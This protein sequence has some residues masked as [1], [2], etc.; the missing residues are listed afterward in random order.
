MGHQCHP[1]DGTVVNASGIVTVAIVVAFATFLNGCAGSS[2]DNRETQG[3]SAHVS[4][5][6]PPASAPVIS[7]AL[8]KRLHANELGQVMVLEYHN[9]I[10]KKGQFNQSPS[11][12][13]GDLQQL[14][15]N[16]YIPIDIHDW[17]SGN[18]TTPAGKSPVLITFDDASTYQ[19]RYIETNGSHEID[20]NC[21]VGIM[22]A[23]AAA[24]P[25]FGAHATFF[26][27]PNGFSQPAFKAEKY[28]YL[29]SHGY[30]I[31]NHTWTHPMLA[32]KTPAQ[33]QEE[34]G[35]DDADI[36]AILPNYTV[37]VLAYPYGSRPK[38]ANKFD[39]TYIKNGVWK[40]LPYHISAAFLVGA[41]PAPS[42]FSKD[43]SRMAIPRVQA[44]EPDLVR[45]IAYFKRHPER[46]FVS[47]GDP[48]AIS[49]P[50]SEARF[51]ARDLGGKKTIEY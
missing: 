35:K 44:I 15:D 46:R 26:V 24:H 32:H 49:F 1:K 33:I 41:N 19:F 40:G 48:N 21:A 50:K 27:L 43:L 4:Q 6:I 28:R 2:G 12:L 23:F 9:I 11:Q 3:R 18:I 34:L 45:W 16:G 31:G 42:V 22:D 10:D 20:P 7:A 47:D 36:H 39:D 38:T 14:Y 8:A 37:D 51:L 13:R 30:A 25:D 17:L 5:P 29:I